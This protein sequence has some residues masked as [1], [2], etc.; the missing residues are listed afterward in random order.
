[1]TILSNRDLLKRMPVFALLTEVQMDYVSA[2]L[3]KQRFRRGSLIIQKD[4]KNEYLYVLI[5]GTAQSSITNVEG[6]EVI[7]SDFKADDYFGE[8][9]LLTNMDSECSVRAKT[10]SDL[11]LITKDL[12]LNCLYN[13]PAFAKAV[14][15]N[16][17]M[18]LRK[19]N[20]QVENI[21][22][23]SV[24]H[25]VFREVHRLASLNDGNKR[26]IFGKISRQEVAR[27]VGASREMASRVLKDL[28][29]RELIKTDKMENRTLLTDS[30]FRELHH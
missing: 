1:M 17:A 9:C 16:F 2:S 29:D 11:F 6:H 22:L 20:Q 26:T 10:Q 21:A 15:V 7:L 4:R 14:M 5:N 8:Q 27:R 3:I 19:A 13:N 23:H 25:R 24:Y 28:E 30:F 12:F 18:S